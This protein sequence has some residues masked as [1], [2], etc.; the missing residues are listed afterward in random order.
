MSDKNDYFNSPNRLRILLIQY[1]LFKKE[2]VHHT[3]SVL[4]DNFYRRLR[5]YNPDSEFTSYD[6]IQLLI[7]SS[8]VEMFDEI[9]EELIEILK[10]S[11]D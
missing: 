7:F 9:F 10:N 1:L 6:F 4:L 3:Y 8:K 2:R 11:C 5:Y